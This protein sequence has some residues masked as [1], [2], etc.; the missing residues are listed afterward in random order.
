M[1]SERAKYGLPRREADWT[2][3][4]REHR[5][6]SSIFFLDNKGDRRFLFRVINFGKDTDELKFMFIPTDTAT[7]FTYFESSD[8]FAESDIIGFYAE[9]TYHNDG[10][11]LHK[12]PPYRKGDKTRYKNPAGP[13]KR[14]TPLP[15]LR[16]WEPIVRYTIVDSTLCRT[17]DVKDG[18]VL[19]H[20]PIIFNG[21]PFVCIIHLGHMAYAN[22]PNNHPT[23][24]IYRM[25]DVA[26]NVDLI[27]W[28]YKTTYRGRLMRIGRSNHTVFSR[29]NL[30]EA[31]EKRKSVG[32]HDFSSAG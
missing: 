15:E 28:V 5:F 30:I 4:P 3:S 21:D 20:N 11:L 8:A 23:E 18:L 12:F 6:D 1:R 31:V 16:E 22:P 24:M 17:I 13:G 27:L 29:G 10:S 7:G 14:R 2:M 19:P 9:I 26:T 32:L 25:S